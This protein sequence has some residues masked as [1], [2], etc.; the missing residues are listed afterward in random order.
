MKDRSVVMF[1]PTISGGHALYVRSILEALGSSGQ[2]LVL[3]TSSDFDSTEIAEVSTIAILRPIKPRA[4]FPNQFSWFLSRIIHYTIRDLQFMYWLGRNRKCVGVVH[5]QEY[6]PWMLEAIA[7]WCHRLG[8]PIVITVHNVKSHDTRTWYRRLDDP[9]RKLGLRRMDHLFVHVG[10]D[11]ATVRSE[12]TNRSDRVTYIRHG[13][14]D[15]VPVHLYEN[16]QSLLL[17][18]TMRRNKGILQLLKVAET[19]KEWNFTIAGSCDDE[20]LDAEIRSALSDNVTY[21]PRFLSNDEISS[22]LMRTTACVLPYTKDFQA[23]SGVMHLAIGHAVPVVVTPIRA[24]SEVV[25]EFNCGVVADG[26]GSKEIALA[27][28]RLEDP[29][30]LFQIRMGANLAQFELGW[31]RAANLTLEVYKKLRR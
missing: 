27:I 18:G 1:S 10:V 4:D 9:I 29:D 5:M 12:L 13:V 8:I 24:L 31:E 21:E 26:F 15:S 14:L 7:V 30:V 22:M 17:L 20:S 2:D 19:L 28:R 16:N 23:Q 11:P 25:N 6:T 3:V